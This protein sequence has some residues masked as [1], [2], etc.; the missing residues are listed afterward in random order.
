[1]PNVRNGQELKELM[2]RLTKGSDTS[3]LVLVVDEEERSGLQRGLPEGTR[4]VPVGRET[5]GD[6][7]S[8][9]GRGLRLTTA[10]KYQPHWTERTVPTAQY[11]DTVAGVRP[12]SP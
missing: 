8:P 7:G 11:A 6:V 2:T 9:A 12:G 1:M 4:G 10:R 5:H 3:G